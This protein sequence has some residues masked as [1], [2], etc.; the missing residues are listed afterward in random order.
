MS[1]ED[2]LNASKSQQQ[3]DQSAKQH[4]ADPSDNPNGSIGTP[5]EV[6]S[7]NSYNTTETARLIQPQ[8]PRI[9]PSDEPAPSI[10]GVSTV[11]TQGAPTV[12]QAANSSRFGLNDTSI[13]ASEAQAGVTGSTFVS[14]SDGAKSAARRPW[15]MVAITTGAMLLLAGVGVFGFYLPNT[16]SRVW[17]SGMSRSGKALAT[18]VEKAAEQ[19]TI[20][21][22]QQSKMSLEASLTWGQST[23]KL[24]WNGTSDEK[25]SRGK[26]IL[27][28]A[29]GDSLGSGAS[30]KY[31][32][33]L[34][35][36]LQYA[37]QKQF[38]DFYFKVSDL[39][40]IPLND[41]NQQLGAYLNKWI[42]VG[43]ES[44]KEYYP[45]IT[46][47]NL[48]KNKRITSTD[49]ADAAKTLTETVRDYVLTSDGGKAVI[50]QK[51][52][53]GKETID[54]VKTYHFKAGINR[55]NAKKYCEVLVEK[56][57][58]TSFYKKL[59]S[60]SG[61]TETDTD[62]R[63]S[64]KS[65]QQSVDDTFKDS[66]TYDV[67]IDGTRKLIHK[68]RIPAEQGSDESYTD[69]GQM[70]KGGDTVS[71]FMRYHTGADYPYDVEWTVSTNTAT[72]VTTSKAWGKPPKIDDDSIQFDVTFR[73][74]PTKESVDGT[75]PKDAIP[76]TTVMNTLGL[77]Y[78]GAYEE[79]P[80]PETKPLYVGNKSKDVE[81]QTD[82]HALQS[83]AEAFYAQHGFY[84]TLADLQD[85]SFTAKYMKGL[86]AAA[87]VD[88]DQTS[89]T[90]QAVS[91]QSPP[92]YGY[93]ASGSNTA[94]CRNTAKTTIRYDEPSDNGC[95]A[96][97]VSATL[98]DGTKYEKRSF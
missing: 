35:Y 53:I 7:A 84:P 98:S 19:E 17:S 64:V 95:D 22:Y 65:C 81:R 52:F 10:S 57:S 37:D 61:E 85:S 86:P 36:L 3:T 72:G 32:G 91:G 66:N 41:Y 18:I 71:L 25:N 14:M 76:I 62:T 2:S 92:R 39:R 6:V 69:I 68:I 8:A 29:E 49:V 79:T 51:S 40:N 89:G 20:E 15:K 30:S 73:S 83:H 96:F 43:A 80:L 74:E 1:P 34:D 31:E 4:T 45:D 58:A 5:E 48:D 82:I 9:E 50:I 33:T 87:F 70:Y 44:L 56:M 77:G 63:A 23:G 12:M 13:H 60:T 42:F 93:T 24:T 88:P 46:A 55:E 54:G 27:S 97:V 11:P 67:W 21:R 59:A 47:D 90:I 75:V 28:T 78:S 38:P 94:L 26:L 16:P